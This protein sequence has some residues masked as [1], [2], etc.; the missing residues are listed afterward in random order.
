MKMRIKCLIIS[1]L[2]VLFSVGCASKVDILKSPNSVFP[3]E[4]AGNAPAFIFPVSF[5]IPGDSDQIGIACSDAVASEFGLSV[6]AGQSVKDIV[7]DLS[8]TLGEGIRKQVQ[9]GK[10]SMNNGYEEI[11]EEIEIVLKLVVDDLMALG[12]VEPDFRFNYIIVLHTDFVDDD[13]PGF[14]KFVMF[15]GIYEIETREILSFIE[16]EETI[17]DIT[18]TMISTISPKFI[19][20]VNMLFSGKVTKRR[21]R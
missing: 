6:V 15:G 8:F 1:I 9:N 2:I 18:E 16:S 19:D 3:I 14:A 11:A 4:L 7:G 21:N 5:H 13:L 20:M 10:F 17:L 12:V